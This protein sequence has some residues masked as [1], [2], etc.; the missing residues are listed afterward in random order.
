MADKNPLYTLFGH[1]KN[2]TIGCSHRL[3]GNA[4]RPRKSV[5]GPSYHGS[6]HIVRIKIHD[7]DVV[8]LQ[9][10]PAVNSEINSN[11][12]WSQ[13]ASRWFCPLATMDLSHPLYCSVPSQ[14][15]CRENS[16]C[17]WRESAVPILSWPQTPR[18]YPSRFRTELNHPGP[19]A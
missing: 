3:F 10:P 15:P 17:N 14:L 2:R 5:D 1:D 18:G 13:H 19:P 6:D 7:V 8:V 9:S 11:D 4:H 16:G 12:R